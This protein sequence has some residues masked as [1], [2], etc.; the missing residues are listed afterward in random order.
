MSDLVK[1]INTP[2]RL[3]WDASFLP[4]ELAYIA[5]ALRDA[6]RTVEV[7]D[8]N[9]SRPD[10]AAACRSIAEPKPRY[11]G[12]T[13]MAIQF[14]LVREYAR[15]AKECVPG[16]TV[17]VGGRLTAVPELIMSDPNVDV[18]VVGDGEETVV[19]LL[20]CLDAGADLRSVAGIVFRD[21]GTGA[22]V[23]TPARPFERDLDKFGQPAYD[24]FD[25]EQYID[26]QRK[27][28]GHRGGV[29]KRSINMI[30]ARGCPFRCRFCGEDGDNLRRRSMSS[31]VDEIQWL[32]EQYNIDHVRFCGDLDDRGSGITCAGNGR[33]D[34]VSRELLL[35]AKKSGCTQIAY[36]FESGS[37]AMLDAM[38]KKTT[39]GHAERTISLHREHDLA[40]SSSM[41][42]G[43]RGENYRTLYQTWRFLMR[44]C[45]RPS[46]IN[47]MMVYPGTPDWYDALEHGDITD[48]HA[49]IEAMAE[50]VYG[51]RYSDRELLVNISNIS[52]IGLYVAGKFISATL[53]VR[54][55]L[56]G[57]GVLTALKRLFRVGTD[58][59]NDSPAD[60][61]A[62]PASDPELVQIERR[63][64]DPS[65]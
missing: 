61:A 26:N 13:G 9:L 53:S 43:A 39:V 50:H 41:I 52:D 23:E 12:I 28:H 5:T 57:M 19:E 51:F 42:L 4:I 34:I 55:R 33:V 44:N 35:L 31:V 65:S 14:G 2:V 20:D 3:A 11:V 40:F 25:I 8:F 18:A 16:V 37:Q 1:L 7:L 62:S 6:G 22:I 32:V 60:R 24:L 56:A 63:E 17:I 29:G 45:F 64:S 38:N 30:S 59:A 58:G 48:P 27:T 54:L 21:E 10:T 36:G 46:A 49:Y 47:Y 15:L